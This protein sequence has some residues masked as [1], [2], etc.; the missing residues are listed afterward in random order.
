MRSMDRRR[1]AQKGFSLVEVLVAVLVFSLGVLGL[2]RLQ[3]TAVRMSTDARQRAEATFLAD[4]LFARMLISNRTE[5]A[6]FAHRPDGGGESCAPT[7]AGSTHPMVVDWLAQVAAT[8]P[9]AGASASV[10][11][12]AQQI[13]V[14]PANNEV[15]VRMCWRNS[16]NDVSHRLE[17]TNKVQW[18]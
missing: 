1:R 8:F 14:D 2:M 9:S 3:A 17:V 10:V 7:G 5:A 15:T 18:P 13:L 11:A 12:D 16:E 4:Q 6:Q